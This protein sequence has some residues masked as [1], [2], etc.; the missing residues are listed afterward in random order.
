[1][2]SFNTNRSLSSSAPSTRHHSL[3]RESDGSERPLVAQFG[4]L[5]FNSRRSS[6]AIDARDSPFESDS[7]N[8]DSGGGGGGNV[9]RVASG[10]GGG[11]V[12]V[13]CGGD[14][15]GGGGGGGSRGSLG[16]RLPRADS[17]AGG[18][19]S[20]GGTSSAA[21][22][23]ESSSLRRRTSYPP[24]MQSP[25]PIATS[26]SFQIRFDDDERHDDL[27]AV[28][29]LSATH[30]VRSSALTTINSRAD[31]DIVVRSIAKTSAASSAGFPATSTSTTTLPTTAATLPTP[32][33]STTTTT[34][35][36][37]T[38]AMDAIGEAATSAA[39]SSAQDGPKRH[40]LSTS[41][42]PVKR[43][44]SVAEFFAD[45]AAAVG[46]ATSGDQASRQSSSRSALSISPFSQTLI[47]SH[48]WSSSSSS[49]RPP[50]PLTLQSAPTSPREPV[51]NDERN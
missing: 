5:S 34:I 33:I 24:I 6:P 50:R 46:D 28:S 19:H 21:E 32:T 3:Q 14:G 44:K 2:S 11:V 38:A 16:L 31:T 35:T 36:T 49:S 18:A 41:L 30:S 51:R 9:V 4:E 48:S 10:R 43:R 13:G 29:D 22:P 27:C 39:A 26:M 12:D 8:D 42:Q 23:Q 25:R 1:M 45:A 20:F 7:V 17:A 37:I 47:D 15:G 40:S